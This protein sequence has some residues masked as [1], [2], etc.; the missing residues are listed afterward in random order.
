MVAGLGVVCAVA[1]VLGAGLA[2]ATQPTATSIALEPA[3][4]HA[5]NLWVRAVTLV[6]A[7]S[8]ATLDL[9]PSLAGFPAT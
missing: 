8:F 2:C 1:P 9:L 7:P 5:P 3:T 6:P 4:S